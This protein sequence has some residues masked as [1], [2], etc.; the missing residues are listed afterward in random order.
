MMNKDDF[1]AT[2]ATLQTQFDAAERALEAAQDDLRACLSSRRTARKA[3]Q[4]HLKYGKDRGWVERRPRAKRVDE[5]ELAPEAEPVA[6]AA[7]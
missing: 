7:E 6:Q 4:G 2:T 5:A 1:D 3:L